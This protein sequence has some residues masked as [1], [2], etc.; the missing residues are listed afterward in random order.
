MELELYD[1]I[2]LSNN[3]EYTILRMIEEE[4]GNTYFLLALMNGG[5][6]TDTLEIGR[7]VKNDDE[8]RIEMIE[9]EDKLNLLKEDFMQLLDE[10]M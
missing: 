2:T 5:E 8:E 7:Y 3:K 9:D 4:D 10:D 6:P 1:I